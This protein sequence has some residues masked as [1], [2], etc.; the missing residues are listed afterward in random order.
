ME[1]NRREKISERFGELTPGLCYRTPEFTTIRIVFSSG[2]GALRL[3]IQSAIV[4]LEALP[5]TGNLTSECS[6][7]AHTQ[8]A[9]YTEDDTKPGLL[10]VSILHLYL[11]Q[12]LCDL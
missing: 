2:K 7:C 8:N 9:D 6:A 12:P 3:A 4:V 1:A 5:V 11:P 10:R